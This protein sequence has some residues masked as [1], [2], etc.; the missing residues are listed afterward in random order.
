MSKNK[1]KAPSL[2]ETTSWKKALSRDW[3]LYLMLL[4]PIALVLIFSFVRVK[5]RLP[6]V[7]SVFPLIPS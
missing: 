4:I 1:V 3:H 5:P 2:R 7:C 6:V